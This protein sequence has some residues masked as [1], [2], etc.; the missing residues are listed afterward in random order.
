MRFL[1]IAALALVG[2]VMTGCSSEDNFTAQPQQQVADKGN[3]VTVTATVG[4]DGAAATRA[5]TSTGVKTFAEGDQ[6]AVIYE[7]ASG[8]M[9]KVETTALTDADI[10]ADGKSATFTVT[11]T[12]PKASGTVKY[13]Y[14]AAMA[15]ATDVDYTKLNSQDG[16]LTNLGKNLDL[17]VFNGNLTAE[18]K[19]PASA[20]LENKLAILALTIKDNATT[21]NDLTSSITSLKITDGTNTYNVTRSAVAGP[22]YVAIKPTSSAAIGVSASDGTNNYCKSLSGKSYAADNGYSVSWKMDKGACLAFLSGDIYEAKDGETL[23]GALAADATTNIKIAN[24][25]T[26]TLK[27]VTINGTNVDDDAHKHAGITCVGNATIILEGTNSVKG[28]EQDY[29]GIYVPVDK[30]L[31]IDGTGSLTAS[32]NGYGAGIGGGNAISCGN[33]EIKG[34]EITA[35]GGSSWSGSAGIGGGGDASCGNITISGGTV[36]ANGGD[37]GAGIGCGYSYS[38]LDTRCGDILI[39]GGTVTATG[40]VEAAGI[41][42]GSNAGF[43]TFCGTITIN[44]TV[45]KLTATKGSGARNSIGPAGVDEYVEYCGKITIGG[46]VYWDYGTYVGDDDTYLATS[47]LTYP[48]AP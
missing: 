34:G 35:Y 18:A 30:T 19:L 32:S 28:F 22:I 20:T 43:D 2:A 29:P 39:S 31:T 17:A 1:S 37:Y 8:T 6:I 41:G 48:A 12:G 40:G 24:G 11:L 15:G 7:N 21:P 10:S 27:D 38:G 36:T 44:N 33:I 47:P 46:T 3:V 4:L 9:V 16:T 42:G 14:P 26:V 5:L 45:T 13:I 25:A 23:T